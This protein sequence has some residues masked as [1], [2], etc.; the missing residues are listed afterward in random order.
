VH[1]PLLP[2]RVRHR[3]CPVEAQALVWPLGVG[4]DPVTRAVLTPAICMGIATDSN[5]FAA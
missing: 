4:E 2:H 1:H 5:C 3:R